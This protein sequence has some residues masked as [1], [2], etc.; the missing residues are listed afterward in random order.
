[1]LII[2][3]GSVYFFKDATAL[4]KMENK[5]LITKKNGKGVNFPSNLLDAIYEFPL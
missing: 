5:K 1:M 4:V 3:L 2:T